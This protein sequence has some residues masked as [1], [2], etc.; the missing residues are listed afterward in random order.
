MP[1]RTFIVDKPGYWGFWI[2]IDKENFNG[3]ADVTIIKNSYMN[4]DHNQIRMLGRGLMNEIYSIAIN[5]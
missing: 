1:D 2:G 5:N 4:I 3:K